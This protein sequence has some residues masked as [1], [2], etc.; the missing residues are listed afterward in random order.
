MKINL[1]INDELMAEAQNIS[2]I[3]NKTILIETALKLFVT[4][5][6]QKK[7]STLWGNVELDNEAYK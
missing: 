3:N 7:L 5:E 6:N 4:I 2:H 1:T